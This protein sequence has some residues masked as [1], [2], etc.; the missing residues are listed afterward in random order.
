[1]YD[2]SG[3]GWIKHILH[4]T[5]KILQLRG[6]DAHSTGRGR[7]FFMI[8]RV[9]EICRSLIYSEPTFLHQKSWKAVM[10][11]IWEG[12]LGGEWHPK[13]SLFDLMLDCSAL[14]QR[15]VSTFHHEAINR[16]I[17]IQSLGQR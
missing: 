6:A 4:G 11:K 5:S 14:S 9:F 1:M 15:Y 3:E 10:N 13:E 16:L 8:V 7:S 12:D 17:M 2:V